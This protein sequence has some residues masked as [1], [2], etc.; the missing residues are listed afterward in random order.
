MKRDRQNG[1]AQAGQARDGQA[2]DGQ[3][4]L[5]L[6]AA[7]PLILVVIAC[8]WQLV[9]TGHTW[10]KLQEAARISARARFVAEQRG[11]AAAG[12]LR[13]KRVVGQLL[14]SA[15]A[16]SRRVSFAERGK[17][18]VHARSPMVE[19][20]RSVLGSRVGPRLSATSRMRP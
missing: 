1:Q 2:Q 17:V 15:P 14:G 4:T 5:E 16:S 20:F 9:V 18:T 7:V 19:P 8:G 11:D 10:W 13:A 3:A 12:L 6:V